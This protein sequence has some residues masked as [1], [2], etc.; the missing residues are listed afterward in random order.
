MGQ[1]QSEDGGRAA[2]T[3]AEA[4]EN[5]AA[6]RRRGQQILSGSPGDPGERLRVAVLSSFN[7]DFLPPLLA[8]A[9]DRAGLPT[10][11]VRLG[12]FG[13]LSQE[14]LNP[15]SKALESAGAVIVIPAV[16]DMLLALYD[17]S[18][19]IAQQEAESLV[20]DR[21]NELE[22]S[23]HALLERLPATMIYVVAFG[24]DRAPVE[25]LLDPA[26][27]LRGQW[28]VERFLSQVRDLGGLSPRIVP[29]DW[30]WHTRAQGAR[31]YF[32]PR[33]WYLARMR[34]N[35][36]GLATLSD[37]I[38]LHI[39]A[40]GGATRKLIAVDL[41]NTLWGG[42]VGEDGLQG[43][44]CGEEGVG[45]AFQDFQRELLAL[46]ETGV[47]LVIC[48]KNNPEDAYEVLDRHPGMVLRRQ[49]FATERINWEDKASNLVAIAEELDLGLESFVLL[50]DNPVERDYVGRALP[51]VAV[52]DLPQDPVRRPAFLRGLPLFAR[53]SLTDADSERPAAYTAHVARKRARSVG[54]SLE[55]Y[56]R[57]LEQTVSIEP[58]D[59][60]SIAR[61]AQL[62]QRTNQFNLTTTRY[63]IA[64]L[65]EMLA[66]GDTELF[67]VAVSD[68]F[69]QS[70]ITGL[71]IVRFVE[72]ERAEIDTLLLSCRVLGR[73]VEDALLDF[74]A[75]RV[76][77]R[78]VRFLDGRYLPTPKNGQAADFYSAAGFDPVGD[79][80][81]RVDLEHSQLGSGGH[82][83]GVVTH[84]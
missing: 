55:D 79:G 17:R 15:R 5:V 68:R 58:V 19:P 52:P 27:A 9:L 36:L 10:P 78:G 66:D 81:F 31:R 21:I 3:A 6:R 2:P 34:L 56:L 44:V 39:G 43:V 33:L 70:G 37:L 40:H 80:V 28:A 24:A 84:A 61:A 35:P 16:E 60:A 49:H 48:S 32:D 50:D 4:S 64:E 54:L 57:S 30:D 77:R 14:I 20:E 71:A 72:R 12:E 23:L 47:I 38:A 76:R 53:L 59:D 45:L 22:T 25:H 8:D 29:I 13:Q 82:A 46:R 62:C 69:G 42:I 63:T 74:A 73:G 67:T 65:E 18:V 26:A 41:D 83:Q 51:A 1:D 75:A 7:V 11:E